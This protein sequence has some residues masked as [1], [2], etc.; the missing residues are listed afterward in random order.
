MSMRVRW[1]EFELPSR[2][3]CDQETR[4]ENYGKFVI[5]PFE[6]GFGHTVGNSLRRVLLSSIEGAALVQ[7]RIEGVDHEFTTKE[8]VYEDITQVVLNLKQVLVK[9]DEVE[10]AEL[11]IKK[12]GAGPITA[13][14]IE[15]GENVTVVNPDQVIATLT[16]DV[17]FSAILLA[18]RG[19]GFSTAS[20]NSQGQHEIGC[21]WLDSTFSPVTRVRYRVESTRVGQLTN[22]DRLLL[23]IWTDGS[24]G[25]EDALVES[26]KILRKHLN[27]LV[28]YFDLGTEVLQPRLSEGTE[29][30]E[31][32]DALREL[33]DEPISHLELSVRASNCLETENISSIRELCRFSEDALLR[34]RNF[35]QTSLEELKEKLASFNL[36]LGMTSN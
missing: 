22:Y 6:R 1:R 31:E 32:N 12:T 5:E 8:G 28:K 21:L 35:G 16:E 17:E 25:A 4:A 13:G 24:L 7:A 26:A 36:E 18:R 30:V 29:A 9:L 34:I 3:D 27:P 20:E 14:D 2:V 23:E 15:H 11:F 10:E 19:R 33:L